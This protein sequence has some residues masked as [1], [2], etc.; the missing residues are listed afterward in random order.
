MRYI[1]PLLLCLSTAC[2]SDLETD[3][4]ER[5]GIATSPDDEIEASLITPHCDLHP[6]DPGCVESGGG[7]VG[8][9]GGGGGSTAPITCTGGRVWVYGVGCASPYMGQDCTPEGHPTWC[10]YTWYGLCECRAPVNTP[11][12][13]P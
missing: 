5:H 8:G 3:E 1:I 12:V 2:L 6:W 11:P 9:G 4:L 10:A 7:G 13:G